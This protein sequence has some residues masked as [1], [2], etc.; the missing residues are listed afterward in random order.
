MLGDCSIYSRLDPIT[1]EVENHPWILFLKV[2]LSYGPFASTTT[3]SLT[4]TASP[5]SCSYSSCRSGSSFKKSLSDHFLPRHT[6]SYVF[7]GNELLI[8][9]YFFKKLSFAIK[10]KS[11]SFV[12]F[13]WEWIHTSAGLIGS[14]FLNS[15]GDQRKSIQCINRLFSHDVWNPR[16]FIVIVVFLVLFLFPY[17]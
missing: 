17:F 13:F 11:C 14:S 16:A 9:S 12:F 6:P 15:I 10:L 4:C 7:L 3:W 2:P 5:L 8:G 1:C